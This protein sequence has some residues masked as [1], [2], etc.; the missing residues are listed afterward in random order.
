MPQFDGHSSCFG[1]RVKCK[2]QDPCARGANTM[3]CSACAALTEEQWA[4]LRENFAM[5]SAYRHK[6][7]SQG[8]SFE[9]PETDNSVF[10][11]EDLSQVDNTLL[12][13]EPEDSSTNAPLTSISPLT[14][15]PAP[16][17]TH[18]IPATSFTLGPVHQPTT[19]FF[20]L[21]QGTKPRVTDSLSGYLCSK[22]STTLYTW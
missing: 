12:D 16:L 5:R 15:L 8:G 7:G 20:S 6:S 4:H 19:G 18:N 3:H 14:S 1:C 13:L 2:G 22:T 9:E 10:T 17:P 11:G 21:F